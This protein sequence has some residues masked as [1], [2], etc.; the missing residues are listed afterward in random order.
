MSYRLSYPSL[1]LWPDCGI[2][3]GMCSSLSNY[4]YR[5]YHNI[6]VDLEVKYIIIYMITY[7]ICY[8]G[9]D[10]ENDIYLSLSSL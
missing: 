3:V 8:R 1:P 6:C 7:T 5:D 4:Y 10:D 2:V 9:H